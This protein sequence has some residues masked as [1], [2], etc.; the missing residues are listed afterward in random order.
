VVHWWVGTVWW[1]GWR[2][3]GEDSAAWVLKSFGAGEERTQSALLC[4]VCFSHHQPTPS[5]GSAVP[6]SRMP[7]GNGVWEV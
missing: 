7:Q 5:L 2:R 6:E 1:S 4:L 3:M